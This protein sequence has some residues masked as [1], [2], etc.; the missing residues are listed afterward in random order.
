MKSKY[1]LMRSDGCIGDSRFRT[2]KDAE[3]GAK[4]I[5]KYYKGYTAF[6]KS[7]KAEIP[8]IFKKKIT[9]TIHKEGF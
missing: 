8:E 7:V 1:Y 6:L 3:R 2:Q 5:L 4:Y 9:F